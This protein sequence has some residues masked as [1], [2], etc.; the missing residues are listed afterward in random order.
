MHLPSELCPEFIRV[1]PPN[2]VTTISHL[3]LNSPQCSAIAEHLSSSVHGVLCRAISNRVRR[4]AARL[5]SADFQVLFQSVM[6]SALPAHEHLGTNV[7]HCS[8][9]VPKNDGFHLS[10]IQNRIIR[11]KKRHSTSLGGIAN[12]IGNAY[13]NDLTKPAAVYDHGGNASLGT[14]YTHGH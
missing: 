4:P 2:A 9:W 8:I 5:V 3:T 1:L 10:R 6:S 14:R 7:L 13:G 12:S 11:Q